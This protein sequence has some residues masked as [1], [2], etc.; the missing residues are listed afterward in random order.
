LYDL[1][2]RRKQ[3]FKN[4]SNPKSNAEKQNDVDVKILLGRR[5]VQ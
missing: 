5:G 3:C 2:P 4:G 1:H